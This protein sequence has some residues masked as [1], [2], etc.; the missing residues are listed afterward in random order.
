MDTAKA[1]PDTARDRADMPKNFTVTGIQFFMER[2][3]WTAKE[4]I[5]TAT[6]PEAI[7]TSH[8]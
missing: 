4:I 7:L 8:R 1:M 2:A 6:S 3:T 5:T